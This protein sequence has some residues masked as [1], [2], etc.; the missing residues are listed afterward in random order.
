MQKI[1]LTLV[2]L[3][4]L[5]TACKKNYTC[6]CTVLF[7]GTTSLTSTSFDNTK[8]EAKSQCT[9]LNQTTA[10]QTITCALN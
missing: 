2:L 3:I 1:I 4:A 7:S 5:T 10:T 6:T 9:A 8:A